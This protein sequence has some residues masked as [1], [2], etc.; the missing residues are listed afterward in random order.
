M[1]EH[2]ETLTVPVEVA[3]EFEQA[4]GAWVAPSPKGLS[5]RE[6]WQSVIDRG[7][8]L[9]S[10]Y[11][12]IWEVVQGSVLVKVFSD[13]RVG[14]DVRVGNAQRELRGEGTVYGIRPHM[15]MTAEQAAQAER[16]AQ[17]PAD[18]EMIREQVRQIEAGD[19]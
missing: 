16:F 6:Y 4:W 7:Q 3:A 13:A 17:L 19:D 1:A 11:E 12:S 2:A 18:P 10:A 5:D 9:A 15:P 8:R 14:L